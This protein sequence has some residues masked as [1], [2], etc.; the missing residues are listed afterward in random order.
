MYRAIEGIYLIPQYV[1]KEHRPKRR[2][3]LPL[4]LG[5]FGANLAD[6]FE[7]LH[8]LCKLDAGIE[9]EIGWRKIVV[10]SSIA[11]ILGDTLSDDC[12]TY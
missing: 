5:P 6:I 10:C 8:Q 11:A 9:L 2:S 12:F 1:G 3:L 4:T 7:S